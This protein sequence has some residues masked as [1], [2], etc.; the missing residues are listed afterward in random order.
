[1][2]GTLFLLTGSLAMG[3]NALD[4]DRSLFADARAKSAAAASDP[5]A[6]N[7]TVEFHAASGAPQPV[8]VL[9]EGESFHVQQALEKSGAW[10]KYSRM[11]VELARK[12]PQGRWTKMA[13]SCDRSKRK[14]DPQ[15]D[16]QIWPGDVLIVKEDP[17]TI[18]DDMLARVGPLRTML[19][20]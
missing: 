14:V 12:T 15:C 7:A 20:R 5:A 19:S 8:K 6:P 9:L 16:Y 1:M 13:V 11:N 4:A 10:K 3:C 18:V 17:T 2:A